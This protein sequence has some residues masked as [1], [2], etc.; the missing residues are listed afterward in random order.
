MDFSLP[1]K[2]IIRSGKD[3]NA[4]LEKGETLFKHPVKA[5][6][7]TATGA[8]TA[9]MMVSVPK[10]NFKRAVKRNLLKRRIREAFRLN[11]HLLGEGA[12]IDIMFVYLGKEIA[13]YATIESSVKF[14]LGQLKDRLSAQAEEDCE[15]SSDTSG[16]ILPDMHLSI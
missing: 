6:F 13:D 16:E 12:E 14:L 9:R 8:G 7:R 15:L 1:R 3:I 2:D 11:R 4:L 5:T 10:R